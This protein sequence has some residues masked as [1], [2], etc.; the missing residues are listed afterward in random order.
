MGTP[1]EKTS[2][3]IEGNLSIGQYYA[4]QEAKHSDVDEDMEDE[5]NSS[6]KRKDS[7]LSDSLDPHSGSVRQR[8]EKTN[9]TLRVRSICWARATLLYLVLGL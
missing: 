8:E 7:V 9:R 4:R 2:K 3:A 6:S 1:I 5:K